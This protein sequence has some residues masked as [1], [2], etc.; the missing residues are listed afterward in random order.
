MHRIHI[1]AEFTP[2]L[3]EGG[4]SVYCPELDIYTQ[5]DD[6]EDAVKS[7]K[8]AVRGYIKVV[9]FKNAIKEFRHPIRETLEVAV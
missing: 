1:T 9:G 3:E 5:G 2:D 7:L 4:Y 6:F 8:E